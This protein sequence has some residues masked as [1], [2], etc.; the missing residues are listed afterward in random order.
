MF[1][2]SILCLLRVLFVFDLLDYSGG[3]MNTW[4]WNSQCTSQDTDVVFL[5]VYSIPV[6]VKDRERERERHEERNKERVYDRET[7]YVTCIC[8]RRHL[9]DGEARNTTQLP[10]WFVTVKTRAG[11]C[12]LNNHS[13]IESTKTM[14]SRGYLIRIFLGTLQKN[15]FL[16]GNNEYFCFYS[17][18][19]VLFYY[20]VNAL[21]D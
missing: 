18:V 11:A 6:C 15:I 5:E 10:S 8:N 20:T 16:T 17:I 12:T 7:E 3:W 19:Y 4:W 13:R 21:F 9:R 14:Q 1:L 2:L